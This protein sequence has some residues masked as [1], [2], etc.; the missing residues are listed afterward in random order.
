MEGSQKNSYGR[1]NYESVD[2]PKSDEKRIQAV[3]G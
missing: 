3:K 1:C 2:V